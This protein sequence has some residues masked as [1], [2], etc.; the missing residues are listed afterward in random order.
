[1]IRGNSILNHLSAQ[2]TSKGEP[3]TRV[4]LSRYECIY[5]YIC[6]YVYIQ[7]SPSVPRWT[8]CEPKD[9]V[10]PTL[11]AVEARSV[12]PRYCRSI[13]SFVVRSTHLFE[14]RLNKLS[15]GHFQGKV[16]YRGGRR[17]SRK[18]APCPHCE[19]WVRAVHPRCCRSVLSF[20]VSSTHLF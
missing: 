8:T 18:T 15:I 7:V 4:G 9:C 12:P 6:M 16:A 14:F 13:L 1:M 3:F 20:F 5:M 17:A 2:S 10:M 11:R 19:R